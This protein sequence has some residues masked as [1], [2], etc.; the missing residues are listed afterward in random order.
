[1]AWI[2]SHQELD[3]HPKLFHLASLS[4]LSRDTC[5]G[6]LHRLWWWCLKFAEDG[7]LS[8]YQS[9]QIPAIETDVFREHLRTARWLDGELIHDWIE[10]AGTFLIKKYNT[11]NRARLQQI[12]Q[13]YGY[14]YGKGKGKYCKYEVSKQRVN[15]ELKERLPNLTKPNLTKPNQETERSADAESRARCEEFWQA[16]PDRSGKKLEKAATQALFLKLSTQDQALA[17]QAARNY[18]EALKHQGISARDPKRF[19]RDGK[20][21]EFWRD[22][23]EP[24]HPPP[25][26]VA[27]TPEQKCAWTREP[28][29][30]YAVPG[31]RYCAEHREVLR[32]VQERMNQPPVVVG[33]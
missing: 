12:W 5:I 15:R 7:D 18:A 26:P 2:E 6:R 21:L 1:M 13:K 19:L 11:G 32:S 22:W 23:I 16:Y 20:G 8:R 25:V 17:V 14:K 31:S 10:Y 30:V 27:R 24:A 4:G 9:V 29:E 3:E 33:D 28:C